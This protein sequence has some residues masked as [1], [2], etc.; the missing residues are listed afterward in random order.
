MDKYKNFF[1]DLIEQLA[2][3][4]SIDECGILELLETHGL[5]KYELYDPEKHAFPDVEYLEPGED[6]IWIYIGDEDAN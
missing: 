6:Q 4:Y 2:Y 5:I 1:K 3:G